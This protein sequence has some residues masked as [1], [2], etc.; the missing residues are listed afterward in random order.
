[1][2][3]LLDFTKVI[4]YESKTKKCYSYVLDYDI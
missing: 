1:M 2:Q 4:Y 3:G